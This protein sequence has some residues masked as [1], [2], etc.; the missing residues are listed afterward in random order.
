MSTLPVEQPRRWMALH[1]VGVYELLMEIHASLEDFLGAAGDDRPGVAVLAARSLILRCLAVRSLAE[2]GLPPDAD[3]PLADPFA[4]LPAE[5]VEAALQVLDQVRTRVDARSAS[6]V[7]GVVG[8][9][10]RTLGFDE[11]PA[12]IRRPEGLFPA[13]RL[14]RELLPLNRT[15]GFPVALPG[16]W[17][18]DA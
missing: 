17:L 4:G 16:S 12:S 5:T 6:A 7:A 3:D 14:A 10:E 8:D 1:S 11:P 2:A 18:P 9:L 15:S 13:L